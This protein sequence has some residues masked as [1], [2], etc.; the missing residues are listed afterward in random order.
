MRETRSRLGLIGVGLEDIDA[1]V[2]SH[3]HIDHVRGVGP[4]SRAFGTPVYM[5]SPTLRS[6]AGLIGEGVD[7]R[8]F[9]SG[10]VF[11]IGGMYIEPFS[12][13]HDAADPVGFTVQ[14]GG[15]K[16]G[17]ATDLGYASHLVIERLKGCGMLVIESNHDPVML[18]NGPYPWNV[19][20]RVSGRDGHLSNSDAARLVSELLH[21]GLERVLLAHMSQT[22]NLPELAYGDTWKVIDRKANGSV[23]LGVALQDE[24][25][26]FMEL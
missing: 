8:E 20:Q 5:S 4:I 2:V 3:E 11:S 23:R 12:T 15:R 9:E 22:N 16:L 18:K 1:I 25:S 26:E 21:P 14:A 13:S 24:V 19:K 17:I 6:A 10:S 7:I